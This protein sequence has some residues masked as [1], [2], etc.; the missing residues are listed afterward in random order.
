[1]NSK[2]LTP[3]T[4]SSD[5]VRHKYCFN[6]NKKFINLL[7]KLEFEEENFMVAEK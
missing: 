2:I 7:L 5:G 4:T 1:M 6:K 3:N